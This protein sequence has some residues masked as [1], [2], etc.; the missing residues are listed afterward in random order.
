MPVIRPDSPS[1]PP[2]FSSSSFRQAALLLL[3]YLVL[4]VSIYSSFPDQFSGIETHPAI[5]GL[6]FT[7]VTMC[8][9]G[10]GDIAPSTPAAK[11]FACAFVLVGFGLVHVLLTRAVVGRVVELHERA[12]LRA[13][14]HNSYVVDPGKGGRLRIRLR[15][16]LAVGSVVGC[17]GVGA[18]ALRWAEG[19]GWVDS[20]YLSVVSVTTVGYGDRAFATA[21]GRAF[22]SFWLLFSTL[23]VGRAFLYL[24]EA[25]V[26]RRHRQVAKWVLGR[27]ITVRDV[28]DAGAINGGVHVDR[29]RFFISK[30]E[31]VIYK[32]KEMGKISEKDVVQISDRFDRLDRANSGKIT[33][34]HLSDARRL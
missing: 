18:G 26:D 14:A 29:G 4:G 19:L 34:A 30:S 13:A 28:L 2:P 12:I 31:Y 5:D 27:G 23:A 3:V 8:T 15:V 9:I 20:V 32:L 11:A 21:G 16:G 1:D 24:A 33:L 6:Y 25:R 17:V 22:A 7:I 10:Y